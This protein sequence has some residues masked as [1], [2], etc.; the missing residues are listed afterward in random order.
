MLLHNF[1]SVDQ[2]LIAASECSDLPSFP[3][4]FSAYPLSLGSLS[5]CCWH[6]C[7]LQPKDPK[8]RKDLDMVNLTFPPRYPLHASC[9]LQWS[10]STLSCPQVANLNLSKTLFKNKILWFNISGQF[11]K[12]VLRCGSSLRGKCALGRATPTVEP[13]Q[14]LV[15]NYPVA[16]WP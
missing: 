12:K 14:T 5:Q 1:R 10:F 13:R 15:Q 8:K 11:K 9:R 4:F 7:R 3:S 16:R 2:L 6:I